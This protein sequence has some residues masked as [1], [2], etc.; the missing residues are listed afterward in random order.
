MPGVDIDWV[1]RTDTGVPDIPKSRSVAGQMVSL[2]EIVSQP[3]LISR[4]TERRA[5]DMNISWGGS[6]VIRGP[7]GDTTTISSEPRTGMN[8]DLGRV[9][10]QYGVIKARFANDP[11][12]WSDDG[13]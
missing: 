8:A 7:R 10:T 5:V 2:Y 4:H 1:H 6:L 9:G 3:A 12:H 11:P 13:C